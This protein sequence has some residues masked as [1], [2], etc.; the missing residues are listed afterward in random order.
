[1][2]KI[3]K[4]QWTTLRRLCIVWV[5]FFPLGLLAAPE[6]LAPETELKQLRARCLELE[7]VQLR[8]EKELE[9]VRARFADAYLELKALRGEVADLRLKAA[10][11]LASRGEADAAATLRRLLAEQQDRRVA[12]EAL[13]RDLLDFGRFLDSVLDVVAEPGHSEL[14]KQLEGRLFLLVKQAREAAAPSAAMP[15]P[16]ATAAEC[17]VLATNPE[18][19]VV[20]LDIGR[21][22]GAQPGLAWDV[23]AGRRSVTLKLVET[24]PTLSAAV[25]VAG[26]LDEVRPGAMARLNPNP[27]ESGGK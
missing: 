1:M 27:P 8:S 12:Q 23:N 10:N 20:V 25:L 11:V 5:L 7:G 18:L 9:A 16:A 6:T 4:V 2:K 3:T 15:L 14:R 22:R 17:R 21:D 13:G 26:R 19:G 24:R